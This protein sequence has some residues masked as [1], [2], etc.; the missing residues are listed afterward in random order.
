MLKSQIIGK[1]PKTQ[2]D[3][4]L[5]KTKVIPKPKYKLSGGWFLHLAGQRSQIDPHPSNQVP[6]CNKHFK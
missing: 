3:D 5:L 2:K 1:S 4:N 6:R